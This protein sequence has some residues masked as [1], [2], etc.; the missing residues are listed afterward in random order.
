MQSNAEKCMK[1]TLQ[2]MK[3]AEVGIMKAD[4]VSISELFWRR[5]LYLQSEVTGKSREWL[6]AWIAL[7]R[8]TQFERLR[9]AISSLTSTSSLSISHNGLVFLQLVLLN[10]L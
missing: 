4:A 6:V 9:D 8:A 5:W 2:V 1:G 3:R 10:A 7:T